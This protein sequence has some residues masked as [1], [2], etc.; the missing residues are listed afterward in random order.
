MHVVEHGNDVSPPAEPDEPLRAGGVGSAGRRTPACRPA[1]MRALL[2]LVAFGAPDAVA[3][4]SP[5]RSARPRWPVVRAASDH[6][7]GASLSP[8]PSSPPPFRSPATGPAVE[9]APGEQ[10]ALIVINPMDRNGVLFV[11]VAR[12]RG[13]FVYEALSES[14]VDMM[15]VM[16]P[17]L[18]ELFVCSFVYF[19]RLSCF[20][21][22]FCSVCAAHRPWLS[23]ALR[24]YSPP[25][26]PRGHA[27][28]RRGR[29]RLSSLAPAAAA[30]ARRRS[31]ARR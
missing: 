4:R 9:L 22:L 14:F 2:L 15:E 27:G 12:A 21:L 18:S 8:S 3:F 30:A 5:T 13:A 24:A 28:V 19:V 26:F 1:M 31:T 11:D 29:G 16:S 17:G 7:D 25:S 10:P 20:C 6:G 23:S